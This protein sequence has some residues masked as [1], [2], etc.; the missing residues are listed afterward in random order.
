[1]LNFKL[2]ILLNCLLGLLHLSLGTIKKIDPRGVTNPLNNN[3]IDLFMIVDES[4][5]YM[6][7]MQ[8]G[9]VKRFLN[10]MAE[11]VAPSGSSPYF[12]IYFYGATNNVQTVVPFKTNS[13]ASVKTYLDNKLYAT[14]QSNPSNLD[15][16]LQLVLQNCSVHC[17]ST[18]PR[19]V[20]VISSA[21]SASSNNAVRQLE[22]NLGLTV[23]VVGIGSS[24]STTTLNQLASYPTVH[25]ANFFSDYNDLTLNSHYIGEIISSVPRLVGI[26]QITGVGTVVNGYY[27]ILQVSTT[28]YTAT[29][30]ALVLFASNCPSCAVYGSLSEPSPTSANTIANSN[31]RSFH[32]YSGYPNSLFYFR[33]PRGTNRLFL[34]F[35]GSGIAG[36]NIWVDSFPTPALLTA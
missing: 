2:W 22:I 17:R 5:S 28:P 4:N 20:L 14:T 8:H 35:S 10:V 26:R 21:L 12:G 27:Y 11:T 24:I 16:A 33:V 6:S 23:V 29:S 32:A 18:V 3:G 30:D 34:S 15:T 7:L 1:M 13:V 19:V 36:V 25:Y 31:R 9:S